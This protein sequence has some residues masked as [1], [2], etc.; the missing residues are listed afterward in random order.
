MSLTTGTPAPNF[1]TKDQEGKEVNLSDFK[2]KKVVLYFYPKDMTPGCTAEACSLRDNYKVLQKAGYEILGISSDDEKTH[3]KF[4]DK[5]NLPFRLLADVDKSVHH[6]YGTWVEKSMYGRKYMGTARITYIIDE[7]GVITEVIEKVDTKNHASQ[8]LG[9]T[10]SK[11]KAPAKKVKKAS[12]KKAAKP[13][14]K[15][16]KKSAKKS[17]L[18]KVGRKTKKK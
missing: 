5:E 14:M 13:T 12:S 15:D 6:Q 16:L 10:P 4:I 18:K 11:V 3:R 9:D 8:I 17:S 1:K 7:K 2:G